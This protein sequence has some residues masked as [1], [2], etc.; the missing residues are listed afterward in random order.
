MLTGESEPVQLKQPADKVFAGTLVVSGQGLL[1]VTAVGR[2]TELGRIAGQSL[3]TIALQASPLR[4]EMARLTRKLVVIG[5][6]LRA[7]LRPPWRYAV[8]GCRPCWRA[9]RWP[10]GVLPQ[11]L[12]VI[13]I[14]FL[15]LAARRAGG[16]AGAHAAAQR[17][18][19]TGPD[20]RAVRGQ[21]RHAHPKPHGGG[22]AMH[23]GQG[24]G[25]ATPASRGRWQRA[26][27]CLPRQVLE[28]AVLASEIEPHDPME[29]AFHR[30]A[31][32]HLVDTEHLHPAWSLAREYE[33]SPQLLAS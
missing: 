29:Q 30:M 16:A 10:M 28:Y 22:G 20:H 21:D 26:A 24:A 1:Q 2:H 11:E 23:C 32:D 15:A 6:S 5:L 18:R 31:A 13:M 8:T 14:I 7:L 3:D 19:D 33:L 12:P 25:C 4:E 27:R 9:S 17:H